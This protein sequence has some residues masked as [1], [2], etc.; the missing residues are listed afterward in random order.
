M[1]DCIIV[2]KLSTNFNEY[3]NLENLYNIM[4]NILLIVL[5]LVLMII[6]IKVGNF[7]IDKSVSKNIKR[8]Y[9]ISESRSKTYGYVLKSVLSYGVYFLGAII[10]LSTVLGLKGLTFAGIGGLAIA[11]GSQNLIKD[12]INGF[13]ILFEDQYS[14]GDYIT[15]EDKSGIVEGVELRITR[16]RDFNGDLHLIPNG[17]ITKVTNHSRG[18]RRVLLEIEVAYEENIDKVI[19]VLNNISSDYSKEDGDMVEEAKVFGVS[20]LN[21]SSVSIK[22]IG[23]SKPLTEVKCE[24]EL[25]RR[26]KIGLNKE[27]IEIPYPRIKILKGEN[28]A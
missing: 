2:G 24:M 8:S 15:I 13:F 22:I 11:F 23:K 1:F 3:F 21:N 19:E 27:G 5:I 9:I 4:G 14:V 17:L 26:I 25:R 7:I 28:D 20:S 18:N 12:I 10:I 16:L 6:L